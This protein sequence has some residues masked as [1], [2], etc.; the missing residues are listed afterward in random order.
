[1][2]HD[3]LDCTLALFDRLILLVHVHPLQSLSARPQVELRLCSGTAELSCRSSS[4]RHAF[5]LESPAF[6][7]SFHLSVVDPA[8]I[9]RWK[10]AVQNNSKNLVPRSSFGSSQPVAPLFA[11]APSARSA[12]S[13]SPSLVRTSGKSTS[14]ILDEFFLVKP[15]R[16]S[17]APITNSPPTAGSSSLPLNEPSLDFTGCGFTPE[18]QS[19]CAITAAPTSSS[20]S[21]CT[22]SSLAQVNSEKTF[23]EKEFEILLVGGGGVGK[24]SIASVFSTGKFPPAD[25]WI[26]SA[27]YHRELLLPGH[28]PYH[29]SILDMACDE[30][31]SDFTDIFQKYMQ[32]CDCI[33]LVYSVCSRQSLEE[34]SFYFNQISHLRR[35]RP[36]A[37]LLLGNMADDS[38]NREITFEEG[39]DIATSLQCQFEEASAKTGDGID[40]AFT[41]LI[42]SRLD[43]LVVLERQEEIERVLKKQEEFE[44][45]LEEEE[46]EKVR[47]KEEQLMNQIRVTTEDREMEQSAL[48]EDEMRHRE[49]MKKAALKNMGIL[50]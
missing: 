15:S 14:E 23:E 50:Y 12:P 41:S 25:Q 46:R 39:A 27:L 36:P 11:P 40:S 29:L 18:S 6:P 8:E 17:P 42:I 26:A 43:Q 37:F 7:H 16:T 32:S 9:E 24:T 13:P 28:P 34:S 48:L 35:S 49:A 21:A 2:T 33:V 5:F 31:R 10:F 3:R 38:M 44:R 20:Q 4:D 22:S 30:N 19:P 45:L 47:R 1:V